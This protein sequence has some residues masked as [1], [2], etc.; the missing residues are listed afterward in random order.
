MK[1]IF[2]SPYFRIVRES[3]TC[4]NYTEVGR[5]SARLYAMLDGISDATVFNYADKVLEATIRLQREAVKGN[6]G[7]ELYKEGSIEVKVF[8]ILFKIVETHLTKPVEDS[9]WD[10][11]AIRIANLPRYE[12]EKVVNDYIVNFS[13]ATFGFLEKLDKQLRKEAIA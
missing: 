12:N 6:V 5:L 9:E 13:V 3:K 7:V 11:L 1:E 8:N 2:W 10:T 4:Q